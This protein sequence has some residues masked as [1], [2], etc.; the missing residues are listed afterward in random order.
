MRKANIPYGAYMNNVNKVLNG[1]KA[2]KNHED[3]KE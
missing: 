3:Q 1:T 2:V